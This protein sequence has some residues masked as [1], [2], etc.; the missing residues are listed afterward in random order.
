LLQNA[1]CF[2]EYGSGYST[3]LA[4]SKGLSSIVSVETDREYVE[5]ISKLVDART[6]IV[7]IN[8]GDT[9][10]WGFPERITFVNAA[11]YLYKPWRIIKK[12]KIYPDL[13]LI[14]GRFR[15]A[16]FAFSFLLAKKGTIFSSMIS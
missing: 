14:D 2:L 7:W 1:K 8:F 16:S 15:V 5:E 12:N 6:I 10:A 4:Q 13:I 11:R 3:I 9:K